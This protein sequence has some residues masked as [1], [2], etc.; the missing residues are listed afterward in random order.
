MSVESQ[1][2][3]VSSQLEQVR[4]KLTDDQVTS[5]GSILT[6]VKSAVANLG[7]DLITANKESAK[8]KIENRELK[9]LQ[10][11]HDADKALW[12]KEKETLMQNA[13][14][15]ELTKKITDLEGFKKTVFDKQRNE[16]VES[17]KSISDHD[18]FEK[19]KTL[20]HIPTEKDDDGNLKWDT[21]DDAKMEA[22]VGKL[23]EHI[24]L[25][26]FGD[27]NI[28]IPLHKVG[29]VSNQHAQ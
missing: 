8:R 16:F 7:N 14:T 6:G 19:T 9:G 21:V 13:D 29:D 1:I 4:S 12:E 2:E 3:E 18:N 22:N 23:K 24:T 26:L 15:T 11:D 27:A 5:V 10:E 17:F 20:Y 25:G 28:I